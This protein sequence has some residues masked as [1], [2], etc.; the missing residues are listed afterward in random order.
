LAKA[1]KPLTAFYTD[2]NLYQYT[3]VPFGL[4]TGAQVLSWLLDRVFQDMKF[5]FAYHYLDDVVIYSESFEEHLEH[6]RLVLD[7]LRQARLTVKT[8]KVVF[9]TQEISL[10]HL[11]SPGC[12]RIDPE[13]TRPI[14]EFPIPQDNRGLDRFIGMVNFY[15][16]FIPRCA[17]VAA[18]FNALRKRTKFVWC[19]EQQEAFEALKRAIPQPPVLGMAK[20]SEKFI[21]QTDASGA[22]LG[23]VLSQEGNGVWQLIAYASRT[24]S[25]QEPKASST[26]ELECLA[27][28]FGTE[29]FRKYIEHQDCILEMDNQVLSWLLSHPRQLGKIGR[30]VVKISSLKF[31]VCHVRGTQNIVA[32]TFSRMFDSHTS[33][34]A[35][36]TE[37]H[38]VLIE[39]PLAFQELGQL[40]QEDPTLAGIVA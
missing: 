25:A 14:R 4:A 2:W 26:Y 22:A 37:S 38:L 17:D 15:Q 7:R 30:W 31:E 5:E 39:F 3:R 13:R 8:E 28:L 36:Q 32:D 6:I 19:Q 10:G 34:S 35:N 16:K 9:A 20:C 18:R 24:L 27:V 40:Q 33:D 29:K 23:A 21:L 1:S 11:V 12:V